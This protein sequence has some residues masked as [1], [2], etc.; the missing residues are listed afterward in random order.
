MY[1]NAHKQHLALP[2]GRLQANFAALT[3]LQSHQDRPVYTY[4][5]LTNFKRNLEF[6]AFLGVTHFNF[7]RPDS[8]PRSKEGKQH[9]LDP[10]G[11]G[12]GDRLD[13]FSTRFSIT[14][15]TLDFDLIHKTPLKWRHWTR[16]RQNVRKR[17]FFTC[18]K[19]GNRFDVNST[20]FSMTGFTLN[21]D[22][23]HEKFYEWHTIDKRSQKGGIEFSLAKTFKR[24]FSNCS[25]E[26]TV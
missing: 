16:S 8:K 11:G 5:P 19:G 13:V 4:G 12:V 17:R 18:P 10:R 20:R 2:F 3:R 26:E 24:R 6:L 7:C 15:F 25:K 9:R 21:F 14:S 23:G 22:F 1:E